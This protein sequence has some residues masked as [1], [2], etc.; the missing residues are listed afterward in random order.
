M[1]LDELIAYNG[2]KNPDNPILSQH[3]G[4]NSTTFGAYKSTRYGAFFTNNPEFAK[5]YG[6]VREYDIDDSDIVNYELLNDLASAYASSLDYHDPDIREIALSIGYIAGNTQADEWGLFEDE[7]GEHFVP[8]LK[9]HGYTGAQ[10]FEYHEGYD[11]K[12]LKSL[13]TVVFDL[14]II[15]RIR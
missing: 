13:T 3:T 15:R 7:I 1:R 5:L 8:W 6:E 4:D 2:R 12:E 11:G 10:F 14:S 9:N